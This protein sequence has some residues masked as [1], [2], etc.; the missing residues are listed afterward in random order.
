MSP[1]ERI[2]EK[3]GRVAR[4]WPHWTADERARLEELVAEV[5]AYCMTGAG[6]GLARAVA[7]CVV[8]PALCPSFCERVS[9][10]REE[11]AA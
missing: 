8:C 6:G 5:V 2:A 7:E 1:D 9:I 11:K 10:P 4:A 3:I